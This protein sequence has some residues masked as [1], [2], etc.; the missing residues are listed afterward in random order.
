[1]S[2]EQV[3]EA[4]LFASNKERLIAEK[5]AKDAEMKKQRVMLKARRERYDK[6]VLERQRDPRAQQKKARTVVAKKHLS[7]C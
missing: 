1:M 3:D 6:Q 2:T 5:E 4:P 7:G